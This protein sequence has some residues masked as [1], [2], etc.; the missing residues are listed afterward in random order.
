MTDRKMIYMF[1]YQFS[2]VKL[3]IFML[4]AAG[5][6]DIPTD[7]SKGADTANR[8]ATTNQY[9]DPIEKYLH[10]GHQKNIMAIGE[11]KKYGHFGESVFTVDVAAAVEPDLVADINDMKA[12]GKIPSDSFDIIKLVHIPTTVF[13]KEAKATFTNLA[14]ILKPGGTLEFNNMWGGYSAEALKKAIYDVQDTD[15][16]RNIVLKMSPKEVVAYLRNEGEISNPFDQYLTNEE[17]DQTTGKRLQET[18]LWGDYTKQLTEF[19]TGCGFSKVEY[20]PKTDWW[21]VEK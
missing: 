6:R 12:M 2:L 20:L 16:Q 11:G 14:R 1:K 18:P 8:T 17:S 13:D 7:S 21:Q 3:V 15:E 10:A 5:C 9:A 4:C 19:F